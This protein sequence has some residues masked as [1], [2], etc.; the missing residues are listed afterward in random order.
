MRSCGGVTDG[1]LNQRTNA[2][3]VITVVLLGLTIIHRGVTLAPDEA[4]HPLK[5][6]QMHQWRQQKQ[7]LFQRARQTLPS[8]PQ[9]HSHGKH[10]TRSPPP[11][12]GGGTLQRA[13]DLVL[14][15]RPNNP[16][17]ASLHDDSAY[18][19]QASDSNN[20]SRRVPFPASRVRRRCRGF[21]ACEHVTFAVEVDNA[22]FH[23]GTLYLRDAD[24]E[25]RA[26]VEELRN[27]Y[28]SL[29]G[30]KVAPPPAP[31]PRAAPSSFP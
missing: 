30:R 1:I 18:W 19:A 17:L 24:P 7:F 13:L 6:P 4:P 15:P 25:S 23:E 10:A 16:T 22:V 11:E 21:W 9:E 3:M 2:D 8:T 5:F 12:K 29:K 31:S 28:Q 14:G 26:V 20:G 27:F